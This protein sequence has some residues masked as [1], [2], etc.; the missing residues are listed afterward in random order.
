MK[1]N[2]LFSRNLWID[3]FTVAI[4]LVAA[5]ETIFAIFDFGLNDIFNI[6]EWWKK[7]LIIL[8]LFIMIWILTAIIKA[9]L[10]SK[11]VTLKIRNIP[12]VIKE[13]DLFKSKDWKIIPFNEFF[14]TQVDDVVIA[15]NSLNGIFVDYYVSNK[16]ELESTITSASS[17][18]GLPIKLKGGKTC[19]TL[20]R[21]ITYDNYMLLAFAHFE[22]NQAKLT[23]NQYEACLRTMWHEVSR[24]YANK[25]ISIPLLGGGIT[26]FE[27]VPEKSETHLLRCLLCTLKTSNAQIYQPITICLTKSTIDKI[28]LYDIKKLF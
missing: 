4:S 19:H 25:P 12:V 24:T 26:R 15:H 23:H 3:S 17:T 8:L 6:T 11:S 13:G 21:I 9:F 27:G 28:N 7:L 5:V 2:K 22:N 16:S 1:F 10:S 14:D 18:P 20:G